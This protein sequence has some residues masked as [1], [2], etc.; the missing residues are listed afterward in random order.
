MEILRQTTPLYRKHINPFGKYHFDVSLGC[1]MSRTPSML[2]QLNGGFRLDAVTTPY[3]F[4]R[5]GW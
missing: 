4:A 5:P 1:V 3:G 2:R